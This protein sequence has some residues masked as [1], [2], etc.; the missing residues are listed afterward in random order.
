VN[1]PAYLRGT[2]VPRP[3]RPGFTLIELLVVIAIIGVLIGLL[4]PAVQRV[5]SAA[6]RLSD[7]NNLKQ[8]GIAVHNYASA[9]DGTLP[10]ARTR[11]NGNV[12]WWFALCDAND[13]E[14]DFRRSHLMPY[15]ENN[16]RALQAPAKAPG[17][18]YLTYDGL[19][20][21]YGYNYRYLAPLRILPDST[22]QWVPIKLEQ[23]RSTSQTL[24]FMS[25]AGTSTKPG[26]PTGNPSLIEVGV[27]EPPSQKYPSVHFRLDMRIA[28]VVFVDGHVEA[29]TTPAR[30]PTP[31]DP[32]EVVALRDREN[33]FDIGGDDTLWDRN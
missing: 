32:P 20:G 10:P 15:M 25:A 6:N 16:K 33:L 24:C 19:T 27:A 29:W 31:A 18:V 28:N 21:G 7:Q 17:V 12:K 4:L 26:L 22:E 1:R 23:V 30:N 14:I 8:L 2:H 5:R 3:A 13:N 9:H 11:E